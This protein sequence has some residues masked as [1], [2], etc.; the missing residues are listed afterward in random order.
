MVTGRKKLADLERDLAFKR[1][2]LERAEKQGRN[3]DAARRA[4]QD[5]QRRLAEAK[6]TTGPLKPRAVTTLIRRDQQVKPVW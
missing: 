5:A 1:A 6:A 4:C 2:R 3:V